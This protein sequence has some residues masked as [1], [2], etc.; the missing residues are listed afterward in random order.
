VIWK[1]AE[2]FNL[3]PAWIYTPRVNYIS[4][5]CDWVVLAPNRTL[6][7]IPEIASHLKPDQ[8]Y[9]PSARLWTDDYSDLFRIL[10]R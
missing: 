6:L 5:A 7:D 3:N 9:D 4:S 8:F 2:H 1:T 10:K